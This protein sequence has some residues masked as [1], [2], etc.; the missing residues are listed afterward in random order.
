MQLSRLSKTLS[1]SPN[2]RFL[3]RT[4]YQTASQDAPVMASLAPITLR[5]ICYLRF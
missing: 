2:P 5:L 3:R 4:I 1:Q